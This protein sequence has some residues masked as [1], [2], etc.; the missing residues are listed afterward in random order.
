MVNSKVQD[1]TVTADGSQAFYP[2]NFRNT[3]DRRGGSSLDDS[4]LSKP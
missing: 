2:P 4:N 1:V 3:D